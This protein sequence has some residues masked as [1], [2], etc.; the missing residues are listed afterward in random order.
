MKSK[1]NS[2]QYFII[3]YTGEKN[4]KKNIYIIESLF[5]TPEMNTTL[6][7]NYKKEREKDEKEKQ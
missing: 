4:L 1:S 5:C 3:T 2:T 6:Y 7:I